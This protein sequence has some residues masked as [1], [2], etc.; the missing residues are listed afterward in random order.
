MSLQWKTQEYPIDISEADIVE[1][2]RDVEGYIDISPGD[3]RELFLYAYR[4]AV[5]R[6][7]KRRTAGD[8]M[9]RQVICLEAGMDLQQAAALLAEKALT[10][11]PV[12]DDSGVLIGVVS[13]KDFLVRMGV[14][15]K[16]TFMGIISGCL[17]DQGCM[18]CALRNHRIG[19]IMS[20][21]PICAGP[22]ISVAGIADLFAKHQINRLPIVDAHNRPIGIVT[23]TDLV[24]C[25]CFAV[26]GARL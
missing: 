12:V 16:P 14:G 19:E 10:G 4:H 6:L 8:I 17:N 26:P 2:M 3:F 22:D 15:T 7:T 20:R 9:S 25:H 23:R 13:E 24:A 1:A 18:V 5:Q 21:P 11:A